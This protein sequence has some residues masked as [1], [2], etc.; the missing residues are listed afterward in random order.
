MRFRCAKVGKRFEI[1]HLVG[2]RWIALEPYTADLWDHLISKIM[3]REHA[4]FCCGTSQKQFNLVTDEMLCSS[5]S[6]IAG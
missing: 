2:N 4:R 3:Q 6:Y 1:Q 5:K